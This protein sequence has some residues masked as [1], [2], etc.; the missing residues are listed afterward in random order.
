MLNYYYNIKLETT[1]MSNNF[2]KEQIYSETKK[3][4]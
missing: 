4:K 3:L 1:A 2:T